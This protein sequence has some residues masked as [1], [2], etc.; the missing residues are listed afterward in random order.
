MTT[1]EVLRRTMVETQ[2]RTVD[3]TDQRV[4]AAFGDV[5]REKFLPEAMRALAYLDRDIHFAG[6][7][8]FMLAP[9]SLARLLQLAVISPDDHVLDIACSSGYSTALIA[10]LAHSVI[11]IESDSSMANAN[12][13]LLPENARVLTGS[14][15]E[16]FIDGGPYDVIVIEGAIEKLPNAFSLQLT[17]KGRLVAVT[18]SGRSARAT[19]YAN[20]D[21]GLSGRGTFDLGVP[22]LKE[23]AAPASFQFAV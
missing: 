7:D 15:A 13:G 3:V 20:T 18:G 2:L 16:G 22:L 6:S 17:H 23:F 9:A 5:P 1:Y 4:L 10:E 19:L 14:I 8:R 11:G 21:N 12:A